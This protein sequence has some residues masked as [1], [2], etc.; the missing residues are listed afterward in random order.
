MIRRITAILLGL[1]SVLLG[2]SAWAQIGDS[3]IQIVELD[4]SN[5]PEIELIVDVP[6][7]FADTRLTEAQFALQEGGVRRD[8]TV[9]NLDESMRKCEHLGGEV[10]GEPRS[11]GKDRY[12]VI[13]DPSGAT[14]ALYQ[15]GKKTI[16]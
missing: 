12:C 9:E 5:Y 2:P 15:V 13:R 10:L 14:C 1:T 6:E 3:E 16:D 11:M 7:S 4:N 8:I